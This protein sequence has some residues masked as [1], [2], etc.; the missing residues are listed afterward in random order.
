MRSDRWIQYSSPPI[1]LIPSSIHVISTSSIRRRWGL[2]PYPPCRKGDAVKEW[3]NGKR[4][5]AGSFLIAS[6][7][8][9]FFNLWGRSLENHGYIRYAE[10]AREMIRSGDWV[11]PR[12]NGEVFIDK[13]PLL[14]WLIAFPSSL[15]GSVTPLIARLPSAISAWIG[16]LVL[17]LWSK[18]V[19]GT[20]RSG[21][22]AAGV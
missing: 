15:Y 4:W 8:I 3:L 13:P 19:N 7:F 16:I 14:F 1:S 11:V 6:G 2:S 9:L 5:I 20:T 10:I 12:L 21:I 17:F 18:R 22:I